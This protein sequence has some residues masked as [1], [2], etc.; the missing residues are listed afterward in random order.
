MRDRNAI[1]LIIVLLIGV[2]TTL[3]A[4][5][6]SAKPS[7]QDKLVSDKDKA[8]NRGADE[9]AVKPATE[10]PNYVIGPEDELIVNVWR[11]VD[12]SRT[13]PVRP[14]GRIS[15]PLVNDVQAS[16]LTPMQLGAEIATR[17]KKFIADPQV[18]IIVSHVNSQRIYIVG[19]VNRAGAFTLVPNMTVLEALSS[20]GGCSPFA[21]QTKIYILRVENGREIRHPFNF[22]E[23]LS[24]R[25]ME[26]NILLKAGDTIVVP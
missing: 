14:D 19:E 11:E 5:D 4:Q 13:V 17:L 10:D 24:G 2:A 12:L 20:A 9:A 16:G 8:G 15:L 23:V 26:Q 7:E 3:R 21:K 6:K 18:T 1:G 22:K 25:R